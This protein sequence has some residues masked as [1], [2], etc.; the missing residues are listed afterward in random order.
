MT[1]EASSHVVIAGTGRTGTSFLTRYLQACGLDAG[2][3]LQWF[4]GA[5]AGLERALS[6]DGELPYLVKDPWLSVYCRQI[7]LTRRRIDALIVPMR[8]LEEAAASRVLQERTS[9]VEA[10]WADRETQVFGRTPGGIIYSLSVADQARLLAVGFHD[11]IWWATEHGIPLV[12]LAFPRL[13]TDATYLVD[14]LQ[15]VLDGV[16]SREEALAHHAR[17]ADPAA[18]RIPPEGAGAVPADGRPTVRPGGPS[19][20]AIDR[21]ALVAR[22]RALEGEHA[23]AQRGLAERDLRIGELTTR[24]EEQAALT[25]A[26]HAHQVELAAALAQADARVVALQGRLADQQAEHEAEA[27][28]RRREAAA[29]D[30]RLQ[31]LTAELAAVKATR[32]WRAACRYWAVTARLRP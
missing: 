24:L 29:A 9:V 28:A 17:L 13:V 19:D 30:E 2:A 20:A 4:D 3:D 1:S 23:A 12:L 31:A 25:A 16:C 15:D 5:N 26:G 22:I 14:R 27:E 21:Q 32:A 11:L 18:V 6:G 10:G 8:G 7:D